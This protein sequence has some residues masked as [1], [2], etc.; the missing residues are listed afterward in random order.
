MWKLETAVTTEFS[1]FSFSYFRF[2]KKFMRMFESLW[3]RAMKHV[4]DFSFEFLLL[5]RKSTI[6]RSKI[7]EYVCYPIVNVKY[8]IL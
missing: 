6:N 2:S 8:G 4:G 7:I 5:N 3:K 1:I